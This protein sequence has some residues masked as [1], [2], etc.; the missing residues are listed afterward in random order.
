MSGRLHM[1]K[2]AASGKE[3][4]LRILPAGEVFA[5]PALF[6]NGQAPAT[7]AAI[8]PA[9]VLTLDRQALLDGF[10]QT[11]ELALRLLAVFNQQLQQLHQRVHGSVSERAILR[12]VNYLES[13]ADYGAYL[14]A[15]SISTPMVKLTAS[16]L[17]RGRGKAAGL[18]ELKI[19]CL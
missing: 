3:T 9:T 1:S 7:V 8:A 15:G 4:I 13:M 12:L 17:D 14:F 10:A 16:R 2:I 19:Q 6:G 11:P 18:A 5:A